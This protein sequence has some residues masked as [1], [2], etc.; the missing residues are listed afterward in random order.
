MDTGDTRFIINTSNLLNADLYGGIPGIR[1]PRRSLIRSNRPALRR[2][3]YPIAY[4]SPQRPSH[5]IANLY[6]VQVCYMHYIR[7]RRFSADQRIDGH[8]G[9]AALPL[10]CHKDRTGVIFHIVCACRI[11]CS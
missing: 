10:P 4:A 6:I 8:I 11:C 1:T 5:V 3:N 9:N 7:P 2:L